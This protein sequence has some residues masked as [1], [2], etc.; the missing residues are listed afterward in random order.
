MY[1]TYGANIKTLDPPE[2]ND[3]LGNGIAGQI[4]ECLYN[5]K[6]DVKPYQLFPELAADMPKLSEDG[7]TVTIKVRPGIHYYEPDKEVFPRH[8]ARSQSGRFCLDAWKRMADFKLASPLYSQLIQGRLVGLDDWFDYT[9]AQ[10]ENHQPVD[11]DKPV[12]GLTAPDDH[13]LILKLTSAY[14]QLN[15]NLAYLP[16]AAICRQVVDH[17]GENVCHHPVGTGPYCLRATDHLQEQRIVMLANPSYRGRPDV[18]GGA[19]IVASDRLP[20]IPRLEYQFFQEPLPSWILFKQGLFDVSGIS[21]DAF[22]QAIKISSGELTPEL[23]DKGVMLTK[24]PLAETTYF[25]FNMKDDL[26]DQPPAAAGDFH[27]V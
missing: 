11:W 15:F 19:T 2:I 1:S 9:K 25:G 24:S 10:A 12:E 27:G 16:T 23:K 3:D 21:K 20:H 22:T 13:T 14:P 18:D 8:R 6:Y 5:Y 7:L 17:Y 4:F 26:V